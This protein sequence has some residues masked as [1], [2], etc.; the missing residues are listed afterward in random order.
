M[1]VLKFGGSSVATAERI[2]SVAKIV[3]KKLGVTGP[4]V[5]VVS[6][7]SKVTDSL[8]TL[9]D[10][11]T[12]G[13]KAWEDE[14]ALLVN[15]H[16]DVAREAIPVTTQS[17]VLAYI[18][19]TCHELEDLLR[20]IE[21]LREASPRTRDLVFSFGERL[22][23]FILSRALAADGVATEFVDARDILISTPEFGNARVIPEASLTRV[24][25]VLTKSGV[26]YVV[27]GFIGATTKGE[28]VTFGRGGS[29]YSAAAIAELVN[30]SEIEIWTDVDGF[31][32]ADPKK[33]AQALPLGELSFE[34][35]MELCHFGAKVIYPPTLQPA[36]R[37][38]IPIR[39]L[40]TLNPE[41]P[42]T[43]II[44]SG[45]K[46]LR[47]IT[48]VTSVSNISLLRLEGN[49]M[50]GVTGV[51]MRLFGALA[52][53]KANVILIT[54]A[55]S[56]QSISVA[57]NPKDAARARVAIVKEFDN[58]LREGA[59]RPLI[60]E[61]DLS[62]VSVVGENMRHV[63]G[64]AGTVFSGLGRQ[65]VNIVAIAQGSSELS[66][67]V[68]IAARDEAKSLQSI[69]DAF[70]LSETVSAH[71][72][73]I[74]PGLIGKTLL[75]QL[76]KHFK[77]LKK[78]LALDLQ[79]VAIA[80]SKKMLLKKEGIPIERAHEELSKSGIAYRLQSFADQFSGL[81]LP[82]SVLVDC[83]AS[84]DVSSLYRDFLTKSIAVVTPNKRAQSGSY[85]SYKN[86]KELS[87]FKRVPWLFET[88]VGAGLPV[89]STLADLIKSGDKIVR[90]EGVLS[91][92]LSYIFSNFS[93]KT[94]FSE[95]VLKA[96]K[97]GYTE[98]DP[99]EDLNGKDVGR[100]IL[101]LAREAGINFEL[102]QVEIENLVP[103]ELR[104]LSSAE[105]FLQHLADFDDA[106]QKRIETAEKNDKK[107]RYI[108][109]CDLSAEP[110]LSVS[111]QDVGTESPFWS[112]DGT[113][114]MVSFTTERY[115][116]RP[117]V[118]RGPGAG[119]EVTAAGV[120]ADIIRAVI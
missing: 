95:L 83:S 76:A 25:E 89:I 34:E 23:A 6:A 24:R 110:T 61:N 18:K 73:L 77:E 63:P 67:S 91:G 57:I 105:E 27:T 109:V 5:V 75:T 28:T 114:N 90:I 58:E 112:L 44:Y 104:E 9:C 36:S 70:F 97:L 41:F 49:G 42:G 52:S 88:S 100:K 94:R 47:P 62:I 96:R 99:R 120:F 12:K 119:A 93:S 15:K 111:L 29:D 68:V 20:C 117:L 1:L 35:A 108:A 55:S 81:N 79:L 84:E 72:A 82:S 16:M 103:A 116:K 31:L 87:N 48:G 14:L 4:G 17:S 86:L 26:V 32:T 45:V 66:I 40:N 65:G 59:V 54:Q 118:V 69:H 115:A 7:F 8:I 37:K 102:N 56:E 85:S 46:H 33:V 92:T 10:L 101:I 71:I 53:I 43:K 60:I 107:L 13:D 11:A 30:A 74:G 21:L 3:S 22:S 2:K 51:S 113:D 106:L 78:S 80:D 50:I 64:I 39:V 98:P 38:K 19:S